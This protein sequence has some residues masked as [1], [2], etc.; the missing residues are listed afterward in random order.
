MRKIC[1]LTGSRAEYGLLFWLI[2]DISLSQNCEL[3]LVVTGTHL[4]PEFGMTVEEIVA[5]GHTVDAKVEMLLS[6]DTAVGV[7]KS[8]GLGVIGFAEAFER[9]K[10]DLLLILGDRYEIFAAAQAAM[11]SRIPICHIHGGEITEGA[12]DDA[13]RHAITKMAHLHFTSAENHKQRV[14]QLGEEPSRVFNFGAAALDGVHR[15][16]LLAKS[17]LEKSLDFTLGSKCFVVTFHPVTLENSS[18]EAHFRQLLLSLDRLPEVNLI[19]TKANADMHGR[20]INN[21]IHEFVAEKPGMRRAFD[22][23]GHLRYLSLLKFADGVIGNSSSGLIEAP[24]FGIGTINIGERQKGRLR[25][26]SVIDCAPLSDDISRAIDK[27]LSTRFQKDLESVSNPYG[28][29]P[30]SKKIV[31]VI[32]SVPLTGILKKGFYD[33]SFNS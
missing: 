8:I 32:S 18:S 23:L 29:E 9:L 12:V 33:V 21:L 1:I 22:S 5:D 31:E 15:L 10:P 24:S 7:S 4:S 26:E 30:P 11:I 2:K 19:F 3:Q 27:L 13:M 25:A 6:S 14:I 28:N 17:D 20:V 16:T